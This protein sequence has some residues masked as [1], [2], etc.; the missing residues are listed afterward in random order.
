MAR[1][2][3]S[4]SAS[5]LD[6]RLSSRSILRSMLSEQLT[7]PARSFWVI[8]KCLRRRCTHSPNDTNRSKLFVPPWTRNLLKD[9]AKG[10]CPKRVPKIWTHVLDH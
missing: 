6:G 4:S 2:P 5:Y 3:A 9:C 7:L 1:W 8:Y 10:F